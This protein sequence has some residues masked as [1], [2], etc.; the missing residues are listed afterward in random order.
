MTAAE[1]RR[2]HPQIVSHIAQRTEG[3]RRHMHLYTCHH[4][5][6]RQQVH[7]QVARVRSHFGLGEF[8]RWKRRCLFPI[9]GAALRASRRTVIGLQRPSSPLPRPLVHR[10][11]GGFRW[12]RRGSILPG[13]ARVGRPPP[14]RGEAAFILEPPARRS[15]RP[16]GRPPLLLGQR[17]QR[18][19]PGLWRVR[20][21]AKRARRR[22][23]AC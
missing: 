5:T 17:L 11:V 1:R 8:C 14:R 23:H 22:S 4:G 10:L 2:C 15:E 6:H 9:A 18:G 21:W 13:H 12:G 3:R 7:T 20:H 16:C 19:T